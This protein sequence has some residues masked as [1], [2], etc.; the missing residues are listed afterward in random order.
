[1]A[2]WMSPEATARLICRWHWLTLLGLG[3]FAYGFFH[4]LGAVSGLTILTFGIFAAVFRFR[5]P[6]GEKGVWM[7]S[8]LGV[9]VYVPF[10]GLLEYECWRLHHKPQQGGFLFWLQVLDTAVS[11]AVTW[12]LVRFLGS[13]TRLNW[14][15]SRRDK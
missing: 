7:L 11:A 9:I 4:G 1:M 10:W 14:Q 13:I 2:I 6:P 15:L 3:L 5:H 8:L 12:E